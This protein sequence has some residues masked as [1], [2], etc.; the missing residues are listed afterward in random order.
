MLPLIAFTPHFYKV[1]LQSI[2]S[3]NFMLEACEAG[4]LGSCILYF[5]IYFKLSWHANFLLLCY[6]ANFWLFQIPLFLANVSNFTF[7]APIIFLTFTLRSDEI[8]SL[9]QLIFR[10]SCVPS[11]NFQMDNIYFLFIS[12]FSNLFKSTSI[13]LHYLRFI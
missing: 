10:W 8:L 2:K 13:H 6:L 12:D 5:L 11:G 9:H 4:L 3:L 1:W 7:G